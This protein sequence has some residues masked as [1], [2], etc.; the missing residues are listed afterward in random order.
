MASNHSKKHGNMK[1]ELGSDQ[2]MP[3][4]FIAFVLDLICYEKIQ[5]TVKDNYFSL[6]FDKL[7]SKRSLKQP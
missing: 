2:I 4:T 1:K 7:K 6:L 5:P 3:H